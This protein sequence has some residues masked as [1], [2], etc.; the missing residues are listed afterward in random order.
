MI[1]SVTRTTLPNGLT[2]LVHHAPESDVVAIVTHVCAGYFDEPDDVVGVAHVVEHMFFKGTPRF[3]VGEIA[4]ATKAAG[5]YLNAH[6]IYDHTSYYTVLPASAFQR[7]LEIQADAYANSVIDP[8]E[9]ARELEVIIQEAHRKEDNPSAVATETLYE[10]LHD[11]HRIRRWRIGREEQLRGYSRP[12]VHGFYRLFYRPSNTVLAIA[13]GVPPDVVLAAVEK[14][15]GGL[16][17]APV[18]RSQGPAENGAPGFRY[19]ELSGDVNQAQLR[20]GWRGVPLLD[21]DAPALDLAATA[22]AAGRASRLYRAVRERELASSVGAHNYTLPTMGVFSLYLEVEPERALE[23]MRATWGEILRMREQPLAGHEL[24]RAMRLYESRWMRGF[25]TM[26]GRANFLSAWEAAGGWERGARYLD[27]VRAVTPE[28]LQEA[29]RRHLTGE[30]AAVLAYRPTDA[31]PIAPDPESLRRELGLT[32]FPVAQSAEPVVRPA[33]RPGRADF[34]R[35]AGGVRVYRT[36]HGLPVLV[37]RRRG[38]AFTYAGVYA[39]AGAAADPL[40]RSG[41]TLLLARTAVKGTE[42]R[43]AIEIAEDAERLG[44]TIVAAPSADAVGWSMSVPVAAAAGALELLADV[45]QRAVFPADVLEVERTVALSDLASLHD[46]MFSYPIRLMTQAA[47]GAHPYAMPTIG[48]ESGLRATSR[49]DLAQARDDRVVRGSAVVAIVGDSDPDELAGLAAAAFTELAVGDVP[50]PEAPE[51]IGGSTLLEQ[52]N[53]AQTALAIA[54]P[55]PGRADPRRHA[56]DLLAG[57]ASGLG[58]RFFE[59]LRDRRSLAYTVHA[60]SAARPL[61]GLFG[62]Y[63]ATSPEREEEARAGLLAEIERLGTEPP[64]SEELERAREYAIGTEL[65]RRESG[66]ALLAEVV[67]AWLFGE[68]EELGEYERTLRAITPAALEQVTTDY[69]DSSKAAYGIV[70]GKA[71]HGSGDPARSDGR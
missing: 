3:G 30:D 64:S 45:A 4:R 55:A 16:E 1:Q 21:P 71:G 50:V 67:E 28:Q 51:W 33:L 39:G 27:A 52:R 59:E 32:P 48:T 38:L 13:G 10:L 62:S 43:S 40:D 12:T 18:E 7:G 17:D 54:L 9:L 31:P 53:K 22:L 34:E 47:F 63:I 69:L 42:T 41:L 57:I 46:D 11:R 58:G 49:A 37:C 6:T 25:E 35:E 61:A 60:F 44:G 2:L 36:A 24:V 29:V 26:E 20:F 65:I 14:L 8:E 70:Q 68:L 15:Y 66:S 23:A 5:G 56:M 19:R